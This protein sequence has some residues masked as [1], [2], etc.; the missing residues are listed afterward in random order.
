MG[1]ATL[2]RLPLLFIVHRRGDL[3]PGLWR[4]AL[5][6][7]AVNLLGPMLWGLSPYYNT[8][9][10]NAFAVRISFLFTIVFGFLL[11]PDERGLV[12]RPWFWIGAAGCVAGVA[13]LFLEN[14]VLPTDVSLMGGLIIKWAA[15]AVLVGTVSRCGVVLPTIRPGSASQ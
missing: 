11:L 10:V 2:C 1:F 3:P 5:I 7:A 6:P 4:A 8:A 9:P 15:H 13:L 14:V 12:R